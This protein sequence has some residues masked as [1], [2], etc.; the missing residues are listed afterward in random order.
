LKC[1]SPGNKLLRRCP[2]GVGS[3]FPRDLAGPVSKPLHTKVG[4]WATTRQDLMKDR[5]QV[6]VLALLCPW[7]SLGL[8]HSSPRANL[9]CPERFFRFLSVQRFLGTSPTGQLRVTVAIAITITVLRYICCRSPQRRP[10]DAAAIKTSSHPCP[11]CLRIGV[12]VFHCFGPTTPVNTT[13]AAILVFATA[14]I[15]DILGLSTLRTK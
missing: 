4:E 7:E 5:F 10:L 13:C 9:C 11:L 6:I 12:K 2:A 1:W 8:V 15:L 3:L 14:I